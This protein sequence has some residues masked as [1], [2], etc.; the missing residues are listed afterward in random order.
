VD[1]L[2]S[3]VSRC[4]CI[5]VAAEKQGMLE[6][7]A[8]RW[9]RPLLRVLGVNLEV[10]VESQKDRDGWWLGTLVWSPDAPISLRQANY[11]G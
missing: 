9:P 11:R 10:E 5:I 2:G 8:N 7:R 4:T 3:L 1:S 6:G